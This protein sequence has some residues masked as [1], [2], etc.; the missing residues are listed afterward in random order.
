[1]NFWPGQRKKIWDSKPITKAQLTR[2]DMSFQS[3]TVSLAIVQ[4]KVFDV[5][6][7]FDDTTHN[8]Q[9]I[10]NIMYITDTTIGTGTNTTNTVV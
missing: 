2:Y 8:T 1:V 7:R 9:H 6:P 10:H 5:R 4:A 3:E